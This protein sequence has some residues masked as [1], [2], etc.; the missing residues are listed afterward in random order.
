MFG[1]NVVQF[2]P[3]DRFE[4]PNWLNEQSLA[5]ELR[6]PESTKFEGHTPRR[7]F[8]RANLKP[9][10]EWVKAVVLDNLLRDRDSLRP[11]QFLPSGDL[12]TMSVVQSNSKDGR[13]L[14]FVGKV[15]ARILGADSDSVQLRFSRRN[16][17]AITVE[18]VRSGTLRL[19]PSSPR[20]QIG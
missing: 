3:S 4:L 15:L 16:I 2:F 18:Y 5:E 14:D 13:I 19:A 17:G 7:I 8:S 20:R 1:Q 10:L 6:F 12:V 9:T 11:V